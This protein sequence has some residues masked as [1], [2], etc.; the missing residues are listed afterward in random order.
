ML[1]AD[2]FG[3]W[4][5]G[6]LEALGADGHGAVGGDLDGDT[7]A[8][9]EGPPG[10][11][12]FG[13]EHATALLLSQGPGLVGGHSQFTV[14]LVEVVV[15][16]Q[17][18]DPR[19]GGSNIVDGFGVEEGWEA[20]LPEEVQALDFTFCLGGWGIEEGDVVEF[21]GPAQLGEGIG[22]LGKEEAVAVDVEGQRQSVLGEG[23]GQEVEVG[24][25]VLAFVELGPGDQT[26]A[27]VNQIQERIL[28]GGA[29]EPRVRRGVQLPE[30]A[31][32][33][34][35]PALDGGLGT[36]G[37]GV[38]GQIVLMSPPAHLSPC[39]LDPEATVNLAGGE[40][41]G[42]GW[43]GAQ[44]LTQQILNGCR[45]PRAMIAAG[46]AGGPPGLLAACTGLQ[47][48]LI[49]LVTPAPGDLQLLGYCGD[50][51]LVGTHLGQQVANERRPMTVKQLAMSFCIRPAWGLCPQTP[52]VFRF[53]A[54]LRSL[55]S[56]TKRTPR[57][58][59]ASRRSRRETQPWL[60]RAAP[61]ALPQSRILQA[62]AP[63]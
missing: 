59:L 61:V 4:R 34:T 35:L 14:V 33:L 41:V 54:G 5:D 28:D 51:E 11:G 63:D 50:R 44:E 12:W 2:D 29:R 15:L 38:D 32:R 9:D 10:A 18:S 45:P 8:P 13:A 24:Q 57:D 20:I 22:L 26:R 58:R 23:G 27:I 30:F 31:D 42:S 47:V 21:Q 46:G 52:K 43:T 7:D 25:Q 62:N 36:R 40:A 17:L 48:I 1:A 49:E 53:G 60:D 16:V 37:A 3:A 39:Q 6:H 55:P 19:V 56:R